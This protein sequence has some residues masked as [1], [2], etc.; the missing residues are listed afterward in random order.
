MQDANLSL[1]SKNPDMPWMRS[2]LE[3][4][5]VPASSPDLKPIEKIFHTAKWS[6]NQDALDRHITREDLLLF[7]QNARLYWN[8]YLLMCWTG[9]PFMGKRIS[10]VIKERQRINW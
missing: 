8:Q 3:N 7:S 5:T 6:L 1:K 2:T 10:K 4:F 9:L